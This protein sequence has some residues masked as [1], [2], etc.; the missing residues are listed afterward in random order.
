M[1][2]DE[3]LKSNYVSLS[4]T[5]N[6][7]SGEISSASMGWSSS[8]LNVDNESRALAR[9]LIIKKLFDELFYSNRKEERCAATVWLV[10]LTMY[11][12]HHPKIQHF[13]PEIQVCNYTSAAFKRKYM[14]E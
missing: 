8:E 11:C 1:T 4:Q 10:S 14:Y 6:Y 5:Y 13:L 7:L 2:G 3:I 9:D 12:G